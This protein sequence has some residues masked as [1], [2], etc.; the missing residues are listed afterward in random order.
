MRSV[1]HVRG[2]M[3]ALWVAW[4]KV[5]KESSTHASL[6]YLLFSFALLPTHPP[7]ACLHCSQGVSAAWYGHALVTFQSASSGPTSSVAEAAGHSVLTNHPNLYL[8]PLVDF[9]AFTELCAAAVIL[10]AAPEPPAFMLTWGCLC[11]TVVTLR[12]QYS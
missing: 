5:W 6:M 12:L 10:P 1:L 7:I 11:N 9:A 2:Q 4:G 3:L 8:T